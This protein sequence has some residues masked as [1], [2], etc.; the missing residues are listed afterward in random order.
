MQIARRR[1]SNSKRMSIA[2]ENDTGE[3]HEIMNTPKNNY[4]S[5]MGLAVLVMSLSG[6]RNAMLSYKI[7]E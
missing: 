6:D 3:E 7:K 1:Q 2:L 4:T 5:S